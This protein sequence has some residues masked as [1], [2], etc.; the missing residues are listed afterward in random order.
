MAKIVFRR[1]PKTG[2]LLV[3]KNGKLH[4]EITTMGDQIG[5]PEKKKQ[6]EGKRDGKH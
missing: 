6:P 4:G 2:K 3:Y 5:R 1:D